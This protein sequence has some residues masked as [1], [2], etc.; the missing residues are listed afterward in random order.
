MAR[1]AVRKV[2]LNRVL[3]ALKDDGQTVGRV[4][5]KPSGEVEILTG[6]PEA[7]LTALEKSR[8]ERDRRAFARIE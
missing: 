7:T 2:D 1:V 3:K 8:A 6:K 4:I 5:V